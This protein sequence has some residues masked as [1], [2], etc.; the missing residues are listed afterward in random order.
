[1]RTRDPPG[2]L[3]VE[4][5]WLP[6]K[7]CGGFDNTECL[8][9]DHSPNAEDSVGDILITEKELARNA[10]WF[11]QEHQGFFVRNLG[12]TTTNRSVR[13]EAQSFLHE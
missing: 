2:Y 7:H 12:E 10:H 5:A 11:F 1:M 9:H 4:S 6:T 3:H 8:H 13:L